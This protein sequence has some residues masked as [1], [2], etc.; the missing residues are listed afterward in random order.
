MDLTR[1]IATAARGRD[2]EEFVNEAG[3]VEVLQPVLSQHR[4]ECVQKLIKTLLARGGPQPDPLA[5][6][7]G[8]AGEIAGIDTLMDSV[9]RE[10]QRGRQAYERVRDAGYEPKI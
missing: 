7:C 2:V 5:A 3:W 8:I 6:A 9:E 10:I 4:E 1:L